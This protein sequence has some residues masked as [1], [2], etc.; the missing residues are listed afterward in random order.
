MTAEP[1]GREPNQR[2]FASAVGQNGAMGPSA[3]DI[4]ENEGKLAE[5]ASK[6]PKNTTLVLDNK[7]DLVIKHPKDGAAL[8][9][10][11]LRTFL[12]TYATEV[13]G[14]LAATARVKNATALAIASLHHQ[15]D[16]SGPRDT[17]Y[18]L[19]ALP[20]R[21]RWVD[22]PAPPGF[23]SRWQMRPGT[24]NRRISDALRRYRR[25]HQVWLR[26]RG[27]RALEIAKDWA[28]FSQAANERYQARHTARQQLT[29]DIGFVEKVLRRRFALVDMPP[30]TKARFVVGKAPLAVV[31]R[32]TL[33]DIEHMPE[34]KF[35]PREDSD[36]LDYVAMA[37]RE[38]RALY[39][40]H[41]L[42]VVTMSIGIL[43]QTL[44]DLT[45]AIA[46][47]QVERKSSNGKSTSTALV[48][49]FVTEPT[50]RLYRSLL[51]RG[52]RLDELT[53]LDW[54]RCEAGGD[55]TLRAVSLRWSWKIGQEAKVYSAE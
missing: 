54:C 48:S 41:V 23:N 50:Y 8:K 5:A 36:G 47:G 18:G 30:E 11:A 46:T 4:A 26:E 39:K 29:E 15:A 3:K 9:G 1:E 49:L 10:E 13:D 37:Q 35:V 51:S 2:K 34:S 21:P 53:A 28:P 16:D 7:H 22:G 38:R 32:I 44:P 43:F 31:M 27:A 33:L 24:A 52:H 25:R 40:R 20:E 42:S 45:L 6:L 19:P 12:S 14:W 55:G 17:A